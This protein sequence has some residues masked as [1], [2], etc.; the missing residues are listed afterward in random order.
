MSYLA[1]GSAATDATAST[2][3]STRTCA[4]A[5]RGYCYA[6]LCSSG[7]LVPGYGMA[8]GASAACCGEVGRHLEK[9][10]RHVKYGIH[11]VAGRIRHMNVLLATHVPYSRL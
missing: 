2:G 5:Y 1:V 3:L 8:T 6:L 7:S 9:T 10:R 11:P 4:N